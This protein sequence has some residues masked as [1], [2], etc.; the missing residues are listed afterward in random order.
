[1]DVQTEADGESPTDSESH[2]D[3]TSPLDAPSAEDAESASEWWSD[4]DEEE[5]GCACR[6]AGSQGGHAGLSA[7]V[8]LLLLA[9]RRRRAG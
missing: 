3:A 9:C 4:P 7:L 6:A 1:V 2:V 5:S 8:S